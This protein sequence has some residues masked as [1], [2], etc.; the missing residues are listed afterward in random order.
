MIKTETITRYYCDK[1]E[2]E[3]SKEEAEYNEFYLNL[4]YSGDDVQRIY[5]NLGTK[6]ICQ[7]S[8]PSC[9]CRDCKKEILKHI[10]ESLD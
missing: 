3:I 2:K 1:C 4:R 8:H 5:L 9:L 10:L 6:E 7:P